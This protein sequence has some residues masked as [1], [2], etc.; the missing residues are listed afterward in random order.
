MNPLPGCFREFVPDMA[1]DEGLR[2]AVEKSARDP[3]TYTK[4]HSRS[5]TANPSVIDSRTSPTEA[6]A[7]EVV[8]A[9]SVATVS[10]SYPPVVA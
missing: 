7:F 6:G 5:R 2:V 4:R 9:G 3:L 1:A 10:H 8:R